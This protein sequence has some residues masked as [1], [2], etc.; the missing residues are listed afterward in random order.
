MLENTG[1]EGLMCYTLNECGKVQVALA[2]EA[3]DHE[4]KVEQYVVVPLQHILE[5][6]VPNILKHKRNLQRLI[7][8]MD[9]TKARYHQASKHNTGG[10]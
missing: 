4:S 1:E 2:N 10:E 7:L 9:S 3:V 8:D 5:T 6:D